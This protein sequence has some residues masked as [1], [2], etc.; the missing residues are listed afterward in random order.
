VEGFVKLEDE[1]IRVFLGWTEMRDLVQCIRSVS[2]VDVKRR[3]SMLMH[4]KGDLGS[5]S[6]DD[7]FRS[8]GRNDDHE[9]YESLQCLGSR[10]S[11]FYAD[12]S[13]ARRLTQADN[14]A[15]RETRCRFEK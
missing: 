14:S 6:A 11:T 1:L 13:T 7:V 12:V 3:V 15:L 5:L 2:R 10:K 9:C 4:D 8:C